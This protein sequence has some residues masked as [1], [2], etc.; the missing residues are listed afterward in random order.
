MHRFGTLLLVLPV[1][2]IVFMT[3]CAPTLVPR[4]ESES[5]TAYY[6][7]GLILL[8]QD[9]L[10]TAAQFFHKA[11]K[12]DSTFA[13]G[14][15]G[16]AFVIGTYGKTD[17][18]FDYMK[19]AMRHKPTADVYVF[20]GRL[21]MRA[22]K[23]DN[24]LNDAVQCFDRALDKKP[25]H[26]DALFYKALALKQAAKLESAAGLLRQMLQT[27]ES[28]KAD[29]LL[30]EINRVSRQNPVTQ[31][32]TAIAL[33]DSVTRGDFAALLDAEIQLYKKLQQNQPIGYGDGFQGPVPSEGILQQDRTI[34]DIKDH[35]AEN[36]IRKLVRANVMDVYPDQTFRSDQILKRRDAALVCQN[37]MVHYLGQD[38]TTRYIN[39]P[40]VFPDV[41]RVNYA[42]NAINLVTELGIMQAR[43]NSGRFYPNQPLSGLDALKAVHN[44]EQVLESMI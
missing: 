10:K 42:Y 39:Q 20:K 3:A 9:S 31:T 34:R 27:I 28:A 4:P 19:K 22:R 40:S 35:Q 17:L 33:K 24:G 29:S 7:Q 44:L 36:S 21:L 11:V 15:A 41:K 43:E 25:G 2:S 18:A 26:T 5:P 23:D 12:Q 32:A 37:V 14:W 1:A 30:S 38:I 6:D 8:E 13:P 16:L